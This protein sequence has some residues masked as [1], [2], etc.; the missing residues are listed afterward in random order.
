MSITQGVTGGGSYSGSRTLRWDRGLLGIPYHQRGRN[1]NLVGFATNRQLV[2]AALSL[3]VI[4]A[5]GATLW[6]ARAVK[7]LGNPVFWAAHNL[8]QEAGDVY[9]WARGED[10]S[11]QLQKKWR[12]VFGPHPMF[13]PV[14]LPVP[15][16]YLDFSKSPSSG[17]GGP[18]EIPNLRRPPP[19]IEEAGEILTPAGQIKP[20]W[21]PPSKTKSPSRFK[22]AKYCPR[23]YYWSRSRRKCLPLEGANDYRRFK[24]RYRKK[25]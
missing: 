3:P 8:Y 9:D 25:G 4:Y 23:G 20:T 22:K 5:L 19:S 14:V 7:L 21:V 2:V 11:W 15:F 16:P 12:P 17:V 13:G 10:M 24:R 18:G 1:W 6:P